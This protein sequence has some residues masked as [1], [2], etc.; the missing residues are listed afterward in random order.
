MRSKKALS[1]ENGSAT[2]V[3]DPAPVANQHNRRSAV[4]ATGNES[5]PAERCL[6]IYRIMARAARWKSG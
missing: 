4:I 6:E 5:L 2:D 1:T 3:A